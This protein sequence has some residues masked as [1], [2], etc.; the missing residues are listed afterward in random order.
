M[1]GLALRVAL[2]PAHVALV[3]LNDLAYLYRTYDR[4]YND[5]LERRTDVRHA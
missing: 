4:A 2:I 3:V 1:K 5:A